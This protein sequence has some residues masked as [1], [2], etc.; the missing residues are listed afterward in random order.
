MKTK[1]LEIRDAVTFIPAVA[2]QMFPHESDGD[3]SHHDVQAQRYL[4]HRVGYP[5]DD[6][7]RAQVVLF[8]ANGDGQA[9]SDPHSWHSHTMGVAHDYILKHFDELRDGD[10]V[11]VEFILG[12]SR[13]PKRSERE[14]D[15]L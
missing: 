15:P 14:T 9:F 4:L 2:V 6:P 8:R 5:C 3:K 10:V 7:V 12:W 1:I 13:A 11:D